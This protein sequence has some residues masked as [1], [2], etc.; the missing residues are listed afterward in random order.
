M[1]VW[2]IEFKFQGLL[3]T[4]LFADDASAGVGRMPGFCTERRCFMRD[5]SVC[6]KP[7]STSL[8]GIFLANNRRLTESSYVSNATI[9]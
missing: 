7:F 2:M 4:I 8:L 9:F 3:L 5:C 1:C 6:N